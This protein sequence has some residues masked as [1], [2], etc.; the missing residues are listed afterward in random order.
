MTN[1]I[2]A[3]AVAT[4]VASAT[5]AAPYRPSDDAAILVTVP[6]AA[7]SMQTAF[8]NAQNALAANR[9]D[10]N[11]ALEVARVA[12]RDGRAS[13]AEVESGADLLGR[14]VDCVVN[15]L[16]VELGHDVKGRLL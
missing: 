8:R 16:A 5:S 10:L 12:I 14:L 4:L 15:F 7:A 1:G 3:A 9:N 11:L 2:I 13:A 6:H